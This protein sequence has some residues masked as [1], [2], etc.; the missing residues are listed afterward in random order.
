M[1]KMQKDVL[2]LTYDE[3][4]S[5]KGRFAPLDTVCQMIKDFQLV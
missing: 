3:Q 2:E 4:T 5:P 1:V